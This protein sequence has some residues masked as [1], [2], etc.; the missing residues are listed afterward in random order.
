MK[1]KNKGL[2]VVNTGD[3][4][5]K[6]TA[7]FG[8]VFRCLGRNMKCAIV[9]FVKGKWKTGERLRAEQMDELSFHV[10]GLGFTWDSKDINKDIAAAKVAW[11]KSKEYILDDIHDVVVLDEFTYTVKYDWLDVDEIIAVLKQRPE[12]KHV[13]ITGRDCHQKL[14]DYADLATE[15]KLLKHPYKEGIAAQKGIEF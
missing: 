7:A 11:E 2:V 13:I 4:K 14:I 5:G 3:G 10:M 12:M 9:Q 8:V 15:M 6:T 1:G